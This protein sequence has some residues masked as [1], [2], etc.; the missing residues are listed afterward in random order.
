MGDLDSAG[1]E[2]GHEIGRIQRIPLSEVWSHEALNFTP[3][4]KKNVDVL[5]EATGLQLND[6]DIACE[7]AAGAFRVDIVAKDND[8]RTVIIENQLEKSNHDH[9]GKLLTYLV[10]I[11][12]KAA[13]W[14]V[15]DPRPEHIGVIDW[16]NKNSSAD[17]YLLKIEIICIGNSDYA[18]LLTQIVR[19]S[20]ET[21][22][23][24]LEVEEMAER[25]QLRCKFFKGL[26]E[27]AKSKTSLHA[28]ISPSTY[29]WV[30]AGAGKAG[31]KFNYVV[32]EHDAR[33]ELYIDTKDKDDNLR[34]FEALSAKKHS[35]E[36]AFSR[37]PLEWNT[38]EDNRACRIE[39]TIA[40]GG[41]RDEDKWKDVYK[42]LAN[43]M[44]ELE[45]ALKPHLK[46]L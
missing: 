2:T 14:I 44:A 8:G 9:L 29:G 36:S 32:R 17:F 39:K 28:N 33:V 27:H 5:V 37:S 20:E 35:I 18:P 15:A 19:P 11:Q 30:G 25:S 3:W 31:V 42:N 24:R 21:R 7:Q 45:S 23:A 43:T 12:A 38:M 4:L 40:G 26:L 1:T 46:K 13:I 16:L 41:W 22:K 6:S 10:A 34:I